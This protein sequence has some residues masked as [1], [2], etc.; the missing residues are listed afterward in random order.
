MAILK[1]ANEKPEDFLIDPIIK[2]QKV[3]EDKKRRIK[4]KIEK[5]KVMVSE[6]ARERSKLRK[7]NCLLCK[8]CNLKRWSW[9]K[10]L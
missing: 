4:K 5:K 3:K 6:K 1:K 2:L 7:V 10:R 9:S 8:K